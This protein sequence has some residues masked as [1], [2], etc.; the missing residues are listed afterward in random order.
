MMMHVIKVVRQLQDIIFPL[1]QYRITSVFRY[2]KYIWHPFFHQ[3]NIDFL[4]LGNSIAPLGEFC[5]AVS[6]FLESRNRSQD[7]RR[8]LLEDSLRSYAAYLIDAKPSHAAFYL[9]VLMKEVKQEP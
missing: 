7:H 6:L 8:M 4:L 2:S 1:L 5:L 9:Y 3:E